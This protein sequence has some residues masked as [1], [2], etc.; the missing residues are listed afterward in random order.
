MDSNRGERKYFVP[1]PVTAAVLEKTE[2]ILLRKTLL[3]ESSLIVHWC[4]AGLGL[5]KTVAKGARRPKSAFAGKLD[6]FFGAE[7]VFHRSRR[8][9][10]HILKE[11]A[12][13]DP[14]LAL[15]QSYL[16]TLAA[17]YFVEAVR[18]VAETETPIDSLYDLLRR[19]LDYLKD[20]EPNVRAVRHFEAQLCELLGLGGGDRG[21]QALQ[22]LFGR[23]PPQRADLMKRLRAKPSSG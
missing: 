5:V 23:L 1:R 19:A 9:E 11:V 3:T 22:D 17:S 18:F 21:V 4:G 14:R 20:N 7:I 15:R 12:V 10:L 2:A 13:A 8:S 16:R 6:L